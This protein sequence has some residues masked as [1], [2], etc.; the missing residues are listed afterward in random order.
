MKKIITYI[1][2]KIAIIFVGIG[3]FGLCS[4][5]GNFLYA[6][7]QLTEEPAYILYDAKGKSLGEFG[8]V[9]AVFRYFASF[10]DSIHRITTAPIEI[11]AAVFL[12]LILSFVLAS[13]I[14]QESVITFMK[15]LKDEIISFSIFSFGAV[16]LL[17]LSL[18]LDPLLSPFG[19][20]FSYEQSALIYITWFLGGISL[21]TQL[22]ENFLTE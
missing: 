14:L 20:L 5:L 4:L 21:T 16:G 18:N 17:F 13:A 15:K 12:F 7:I 1:F 3:I 11:N 19:S 22:K 8:Y 9:S 10:T 6:P 2:K